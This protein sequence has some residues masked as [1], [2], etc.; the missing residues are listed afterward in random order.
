[1]TTGGYPA[2]SIGATGVPAGWSFTD[3]GNGTAT[4]SGTPTAAEVG[5]N[6]ID[7]SAVSV[8]GTASQSLVVTVASAPVAPTPIF[9]VPIS[10][11]A[12]TV[13]TAPPT[14]TAPPTTT[15]AP[16]GRHAP[17]FKS[18]ASATAS[19]GHRFSFTV[20]AVGEPIPT[21]GHSVLPKGLVWAGA[22]GGHATI[23][24]VPQMKA[25]GTAHVLLRASSAAGSATQVLI[26][27]VL[28]RPRLSS[29]RL[30][31]GAVGRPYRF[32]LRALGF[33]KPDLRE[34]GA[35]P[36]G[37]SFRKTADGELNVSGTPEPGS[38]GAHHIR[39]VASNPMGKVTVN[40]TLMIKGPGA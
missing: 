10:G 8:A 6:T 4:I 15:P 23:S 13:T 1:M 21:L 27:R 31:S 35:L 26:I 20:T 32:A 2:P 39:V 24:G 18:A 3:N 22:K 19:V 34:S 16:S 14:S 29:S 25:A 37:L 17:A 36:A 33:P 7:L 40:Y 9:P 28:S 30:P 5:A 38:A 12:T 11:P